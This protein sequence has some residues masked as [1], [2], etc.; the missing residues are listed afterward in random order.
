MSNDMK[1][2]I[3][4]LL[5][6]LEASVAGVE[7]VKAKM[8]D[9][10]MDPEHRAAVASLIKERDELLGRVKTIQRNI[11]SLKTK[12]V[13]ENVEEKRPWIANFEPGDVFTG[14]E[15]EFEALVA[16]MAMESKEGGG[17]GEVGVSGTGGVE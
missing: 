8:M 10:A 3:A 17:A 5:N 2:Q 11:E 12:T 4:N 9:T 13:R 16:R 6:K 14:S 1:K 7:D 15:E